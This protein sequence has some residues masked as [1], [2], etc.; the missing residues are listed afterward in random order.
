MGT[1]KGQLHV[2]VR[3]DAS[4]DHQFSSRI[5][6]AVCFHRESIADDRDLAVINEKVRDV[7]IY[8]RDDI[9]VLDESLHSAPLPMNLSWLEL[10]FGQP[11]SENLLF[12]LGRVWFLFDRID[13]GGSASY[14]HRNR[15]QAIAPGHRHLDSRTGFLFRK[16]TLESG[17]IDAVAVHCDQD[18]ADVQSCFS[19]G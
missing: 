17:W 15:E 16:T 9:A 5:D 1:A 18:V 12:E 2:S 8:C 7:V 10:L 4:R 11:R 6:R 13:N 14:L 19:G 3:I